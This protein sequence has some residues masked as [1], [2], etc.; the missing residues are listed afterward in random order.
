MY[1]ISHSWVGMLIIYILSF[2]VV[3]RFRDIASDDTTFLSRVITGDGS[4]LYGYG[5][6]IKQQSS[7]WESQNSMRLKK[8]RQEKSKVA[9]MLIIFFD[10]KG[11]ARKEFILT[12]QTVN[13]P[14][15]RDFYCDCVKYA[16]TVP[17]TLATK[18]LAVT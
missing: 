12:S 2:G 11:I 6:E 14:Y 17:Q 15:Y 8:A 16:N 9:S 10:I 7:Q 4:W 13:P 18:E 5:P 3:M 1:K